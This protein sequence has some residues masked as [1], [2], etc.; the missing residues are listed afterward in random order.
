MSYC[1][2]RLR[3]AVACALGAAGGLL[4]LSVPASAAEPTQAE[5]LQQIEALRAKV[6]KLEANQ[7]ATTQRL[8]TREVDATVNQVFRDADARSQY[9]Q[10]QGFSAGWSKGK[11]LI[12]SEDGNYVLNPSI[13]MQF[14]YVANFREEASTTSGTPPVTDEDP[15]TLESGFEVRRLKFVFEGNVF[16]PDIKYKFQ[17]ATSRSA[18]TPVLEEGFFTMGAARFL[19]DGFKDFAFKFGQ[20]K[21][22]TF[23][24]EIT[25]SKRQL[26]VD[27]SM[28][29]EMLAGGVTD[30][31]QGVSLIWDDG[32]DG[33]PLRGEVSYVDGINTDNTNFF[34]AGGSTFYDVANPDYG[35]VGR[36]EY[37]AFGNWKQYDDFTALGNAEDMLVFGVGVNFSEAGNA[38]VL[39]HT[40]DVQYETGRLGAYAAL[41]GAA[42]DND[43]ATGGNWYDW[44][45]LAQAGYMLNDKWEVFGRYDFVGLDEDRSPDAENEFHEVTA[46]VNYYLDKHNL[47][48][49]ADVTY[50]PNGTPLSGGVADG[51]GHL[52]DD[53]DDTQFVFR[54]QF[55]LLL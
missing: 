12:Q 44:G 43:N 31:E 13:Q 30:Y 16:A 23:H 36:L 46:G 34:D 20:F 29:N 41:I 1:N 52:G 6:E 17:W 15:D 25:S 47:K 7:S 14:R 33:L 2:R 10:A 54:A 4:A 27:R 28:L 3:S 39:L 48:F 5:L 32:A 55:Q 35:L 19:G 51:I 21:D 49:T 50:L 53:G 18:G 11:F 45:F 8:D 24:E 22:Y 40:V 26:A 42:T 37:L 9:L 38:N